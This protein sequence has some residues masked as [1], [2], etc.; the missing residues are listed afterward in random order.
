MMVWFWRGSCR[1]VIEIIIK[2][3]RAFDVRGVFLFEI[4]GFVVLNDE[5]IF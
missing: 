4:L 2:T 1:A 5:L 3:P